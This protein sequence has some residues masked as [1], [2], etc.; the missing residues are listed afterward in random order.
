MREID[1]MTAVVT[2]GGGAIGSV[3]AE[4]LVDLGAYVVIVG[5]GEER[6]R[7]VADKHPGRIHPFS[8]DIADTEA[9]DGLRRW[10]E[11]QMSGPARVLVTAAGLNHRAPFVESSPQQWEE[12]WRTNVLGT[13]LAAHTLLPGML[14]AGFGRMIFVS[15]AGAHIGLTERSGY[16][17]TK[18]AVEAF[19]RSLAAE[20][21]LAGVTVNCIAPGVVPTELN[22]K[23]LDSRPDIRDAM[24]RAVPAG[25][26]GHPGE[27]AAAF[28]F[29]VQSEYSQGSTV[30]VDGGWTAV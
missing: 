16:T 18:G 8:M 30:V 24:L 15:S 26:F 10:I 13:M 28:R 25:R 29:L 5:R 21:A 17:A 1:G 12:M 27:L 19:A 14:S 20:V 23:W 3:A 22:Q 7:R 6:L 9:W 4:T 2:G 11:E